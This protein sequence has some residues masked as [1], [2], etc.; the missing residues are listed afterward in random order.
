[1]DQIREEQCQ[2]GNEPGPGEVEVEVYVSEEWEPG[3]IDVGPL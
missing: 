3:L 2:Q 1:M